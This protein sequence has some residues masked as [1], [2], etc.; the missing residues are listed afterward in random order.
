MKNA[1]HYAYKSINLFNIICLR[2]YVRTSRRESLSVCHCL[3]VCFFVFSFFSIFIPVQH[4][5]CIFLPFSSFYLCSPFDL[6][7]SIRE[8]PSEIWIVLSR[9]GVEDLMRLT[10]EQDFSVWINEQV[11]CNKRKKCIGCWMFNI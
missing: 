7:Y 2:F 5:S 1:W 6:E 4:F 3:A 8:Q 10:M 11:Y 9:S